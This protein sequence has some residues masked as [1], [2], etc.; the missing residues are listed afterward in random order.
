MTMTDGSEDEPDDPGTA[1][2]TSSTS[3]PGR[4]A[5]ARRG[6]ALRRPSAARCSSS[7]GCGSCRAAPTSRARSRGRSR[8]R[9]RGAAARRVV[10]FAGDTFDLLRDGR[11]DPDAALA[12]HPAA[13]GRARARSSTARNAASSCCPGIRDARARVRRACRRRRC[14]RAAG[15]V[16]LAC[17]LEIDTGAGVRV[18]RVEPGHQ[19]DPAAA[20]GDPRD[21]NDHPL[22]VHLERDVLP[23]LRERRR[24]RRTSGWRASRTPIPADMGALVASRFTYRRLVP[25]RGVAHAARCWPCSPCSSRSSRSRARRATSSA[26]IFRCSPA[27]L[28]DR[29][30]ARRGRVGVR[31]RAA[32]RFARFDLVVV[33]VRSR[34]NDAPRGVAVGLAAG[35][36]AGLITGHSGRAELT[37]LGGGAFY[38]NCGTAGRSRRSGRDA[39]RPAR[40]CTPRACAARG[41]SS[42]RA[43]SCG[44]ACGT[45]PATCRSARCSNGSR[46]ASAC[47]RAGRRRRS[48]STRAPSRGRRPATPPRCGAATRRIGATAIAFAGVVEP[49]VGGDAAARVTPDRARQFAPIEVPEVAAALVAICGIGLLL[50]ARGVRRGQ[51]HAWL[52]AQRAAARRASSATSPRASTSKRRSSPCS[53]SAFLVV[54]RDDFAAPGEPVVVAARRSAS[55]LVAVAVAIVG[56][57]VGV[58]LRHPR[59]VAARDRRGGRASDSSAIKID[60]AAAQHRPSRV[61]RAA[62]GRRRHRARRSAGCCS[63]PRSRRATVVVPA[64]VA[65]AGAVP[66]RAV[67]R[68]LA[69]VLRAARRQGVVRLPRHARRVPRAQRHRARVARSDRP[70]RPARRG[71]GARS[72]SSPTSTAGRSR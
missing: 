65:R 16:A 15:R 12:A 64:A 59:P 63:G 66:R 32:P 34:D 24:R 9:S 20:F 67:R 53:S 7:A 8:T 46:R 13:R 11:P 70:G 39:R 41:S 10:V 22:V 71:V 47:A 54:H 68:R 56:G 40:R 52:L 49:R 6:S 45:A 19:L 35:G 2:P 42:R 14:S 5:I 31:R 38:A 33:A 37:D 29:A 4:T 30:R 72:A 3:R 51:R 57:T 25:P 58:A 18:V 26:H 27:G 43:R 44:R 21:P 23:G 1:A 48:P 61:A 60:R 17:V 28:R 62:R 50:L 36:G 69:V 55:S